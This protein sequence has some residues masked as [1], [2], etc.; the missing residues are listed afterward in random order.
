MSFC[1]L[2]HLRCQRLERQ[3]VREANFIRMTAVP[4]QVFVER[5][6]CRLIPQVGCRPSFSSSQLKPVAVGS[7]YCGVSAL[8]F[9]PRTAHSSARHDISPENFCAYPRP[10]LMSSSVPNH[11]YHHF[12]ICRLVDSVTYCIIFKPPEVP[13]DWVLGASNRGICRLCQTVATR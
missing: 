10:L 6:P 7:G 8:Y 11:S 5:A 4:L 2:V 13:V 1:Q 3:H 9:S 12:A